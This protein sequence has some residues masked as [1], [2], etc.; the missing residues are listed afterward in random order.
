M[1]YALCHL[2]YEQIHLFKHAGMYLYDSDWSWWMMEDD[3]A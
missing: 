1:I 3:D 2:I